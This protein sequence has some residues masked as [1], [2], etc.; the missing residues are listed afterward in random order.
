MVSRNSHSI[1]YVEDE[2]NDAML[3]MLAFKRAGLTCALRIAT[4]GKEALACL[5]GEGAV[6]D[7]S[8]APLPAVVLLDLNLPRLTGFEVL[9]RIR[10]ESRLQDL[11]VIIFTSS[12]EAIDCDKAVALGATEFKVKPQS[13]D[14]FVDIARELAAFCA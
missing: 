6:A 7:G 1:L 8:G 9:T 12:S 3:M 11:P 4:D 2:E 5:L 13:I 14:G 10:Q